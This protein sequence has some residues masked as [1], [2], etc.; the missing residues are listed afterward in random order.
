[1]RLH[2]ALAFVVIG[3]ALVLAACKRGGD[4]GTSGT[5]VEV[6]AG[7]FDKTALLT[8]FGQCA[9]GTYRDFNAAAIELDASAKRADSEATPAARD[10]ARASWNKAID[11]WQRAE[12]FDLGPIAATGMP[13][14]SDLRDPIYAWPL[15]NRCLIEQQ[16]ADKTYERPELATALVNTRGLAAAEYLLFYEGTDNAC[17]PSS[18]LNTGGTWAA[19]GADEIAKRKFAYARALA[20]D[21][22]SRSQS[23]VGAWDPAAGNFLGTLTSAGPGKVYASQQMA[24]NAVSNAFFYIDDFV[25]NMKLGVPAGFNPGCS[26]PPCVALVES[27]WAHRSKEH[28]KNNLLAFDH[29]L[30][31]CTADGSGLGWDDL[32]V[33]VGDEALSKKL[34]DALATS[35]A[36]LD[37]LAQPTLEDDLVKDAAGVKKLYDSLRVIVVLL[38]T[39]FVT[40]LDLELPKRVEGDND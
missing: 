5:G 6:D 13:G 27:P 2:Q 10:A 38:K 21:T 20:A 28:L 9:L 1:M 17:S 7:A 8:A 19:L 24:F 32:L 12:L 36:L 23:L 29:M 15:V 3:S 31:G 26:T 34:V 25:K 4:S 11:A 18:T 30:R 16:L 39:E 35:R 33:A 37:A 22:L 40:V 14:G